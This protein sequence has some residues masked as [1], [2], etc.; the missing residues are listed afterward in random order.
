[1]HSKDNGWRVVIIEPNPLFAGMHRATGNEVVDFLSVDV[2]GREIE[3]M[4]GLDTTRQSVGVIVLENLMH[5]AS[6][7]EYM[8]SI[9]YKLDMKIEYN[10]AFTAG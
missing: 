7:T 5:E 1:M 2:E 3:V 9:H 8:R 6:Y 10:Y 4:K